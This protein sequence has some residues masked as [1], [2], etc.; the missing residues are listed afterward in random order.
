GSF[1]RAG[2]A[3][4]SDGFARIDLEADILEHGTIGG[5][6]ENHVAEFDRAIHVA[7]ELDGIGLVGDRSGN[8]EHFGDA[9]ARGHGALHDGILH[10]QR[11]DRVEEA[12]DVEDERHDD[13]D[14]EATIEHQR[15][16]HHDDDGHGDTGEGVDDGHHD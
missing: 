4:Q 3:D 8:I 10:G 5:I 14:L 7:R 11:A 16:A 13:A 6:A 12:L 15:A 1:A 2:G 9:A